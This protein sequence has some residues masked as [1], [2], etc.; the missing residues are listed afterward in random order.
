MNWILLSRL[1]FIRSNHALHSS[2]P[3]PRSMTWKFAIIVAIMSVQTWQQCRL[4][5]VEERMADTFW[6]G[7]ESIDNA[8]LPLLRFPA[9]SAELMKSQQV[10]LPPVSTH[11]LLLSTLNVSHFPTPSSRANPLALKRYCQRSTDDI[12]C[13]SSTASHKFLTQ[14]TLERAC[15][16]ALGMGHEG[17]G[18]YQILREKIRIA[19]RHHSFNSTTD[20]SS[21]ARILC[22][23]YT[24]QQKHDQA[25]T[26]A[27]SWGHQCDGFLIFSNATSSIV[28]EMWVDLSQQ[29]GDESYQNLWQKVR[30]IWS[31]IQKNYVN[32]FDF[33]HL[34]GDDMYLIV[35]NLRHLVSNPYT[36][37]SDMHDRPLFLG[38]WIRQK[39]GYYV[40]GG[41]GYTLNRVSL[42]RLV[43][44][45][46]PTCFPHTRASSEDRL[47]SLCFRSAGIV[48]NDTRDIRTGEQTYHDC[49]PQ[50]LYYDS[51]PLPINARQEPQRHRRRPSFHARAVAYWE[52]L[53]FVPFSISGNNDTNFT[54]SAVTQ[55]VGRKS[56]LEAAARY[57]V[58]FHKIYPPAMITRIH[59]ILHPVLCPSSSIV[60]Q[61]STSGTGI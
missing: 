29:Y 14:S 48:A 61:L 20:V 55:R 32:H 2:L 15:N 51:G 47:I 22:A 34:G 17:D 42:N 46:L 27:W 50:A 6:V 7:V 10:P 36:S 60:G 23:I 25:I 43:N 16:E 3:F 33:F 41:P 45:I 54:G 24:Y 21:A 5:F 58:S 13:L 8:T 37:H 18:G 39:N 35:N 12:R 49:S 31:Y 38:Q 56:G 40:G 26:T 19:P 59:V 1:K 44:D 28:P 9:Y 52:S 11:M 4:L 53:P 57:S 30:N